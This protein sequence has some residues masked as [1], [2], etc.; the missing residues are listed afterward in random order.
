MLVRNYQSVSRDWIKLP[1][2]AG[3]FGGN[4]AVFGEMSLIENAH[5]SANVLAE[6]EVE[7]LH[8]SLEDFYEIIAWRLNERALLRLLERGAA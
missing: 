3:H 1:A 8:L 5:A 2:L 7:V 4:S 6:G